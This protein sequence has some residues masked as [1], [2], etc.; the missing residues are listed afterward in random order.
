MNFHTVLIQQFVGREFCR[1]FIK[2]ERDRPDMDQLETK[3]NRICNKTPYE[4]R[5]HIEDVRNGGSI[6]RNGSDVIPSASTR[7]VA[8]MMA[9][10]QRVTSGNMDL[11]ETVPTTEEYMEGKFVCAILPHLEPGL[12]LTLRDHIVMMIAMSDNASTGPLADKIGL[13]AVNEFCRDIG[14]KNTTH[15][16]GFPNTELDD[17]VPEEGNTTTANDQGLLLTKIVE[18]SQRA[19]A[20][21]ELGCTRELCQEAI[22]ILNKQKYRRRLRGLVPKEANVA[23]KTG[24]VVSSWTETGPVSEG[25]HDIGIVSNA[26]EPL[27]TIAAFTNNISETLDGG[28]PPHAHAKHTIALLNRIC[29]DHFSEGSTESIDVDYSP[30]IVM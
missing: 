27:Y 24:T 28:W 8:I 2:S 9:I 22:K 23:H 6:H 11:S 14:M 21:A 13:D 7:K 19:E 15:R 29:W 10:F 20:A 25:Y 18:G 4:V 30:Y 17:R 16:V 12:E 3:L 5:W 26:S 1:G